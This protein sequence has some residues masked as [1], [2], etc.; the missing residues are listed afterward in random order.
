VLV[1][2]PVT[3]FV[4]EDTK[5]YDELL[6]VEQFNTGVTVIFSAAYS[7]LPVTAGIPPF[8]AAGTRTG[9]LILIARQHFVVVV[10]DFEIT[11]ESVFPFPNE[12]SA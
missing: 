1:T 4:V 3:L 7:I 2:V 11:S 6:I 8:D 12:S 5:V 10:A 9:V